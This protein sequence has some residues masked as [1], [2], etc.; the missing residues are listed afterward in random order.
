MAV[1]IPEVSEKAAPDDLGPHDLAAWTF[2][3]STAQ[4]YARQWTQ[5]TGE[6]HGYRN[7]AYYNFDPNDCTNFLSQVWHQAG[8]PEQFGGLGPPDLDWYGTKSTGNSS[9]NWRLVNNFKH[10]WVEEFYA[11]VTYVETP[12]ADYNSASPGDGIMWD[13]NDDNNPNTHNYTHFVIED[14]YGTNIT[15]T[16]PPSGH[17]DYFSGDVVQQHDKDRYKAPW[18]YG[19]RNGNLITRGGM[20]AVT[21]QYVGR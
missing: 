10:F 18:N 17:V 6:T 2:N 4:A 11:A 8:I 1:A 16:D 9:P 15:Y 19:Y 21:V 12:S 3:R 14:S 5:N 20:H 7:S 13:W